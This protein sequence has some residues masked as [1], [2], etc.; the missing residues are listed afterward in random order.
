MI[1][2]RQEIIEKVI[3][4]KNTLITVEEL[5]KWAEETYLVLEVDDYNSDDFSVSNE[6]LCF[7]DMLNLNSIVKSDIPEILRFLNTAAGEEDKSFK[8]WEE[9][10]N[11][12]DMAQAGGSDPLK[13][14]DAIDAIRGKMGLNK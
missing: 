4:W 6:I 13:A 5:H 3:A 1:I 9:Y 14:I 7:L 11:R 10:W 2:K 8:K 12:I